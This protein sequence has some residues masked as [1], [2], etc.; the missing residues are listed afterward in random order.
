MG[1]L[2]GFLD[3]A[4]FIRWLLAPCPIRLRLALLARDVGGAP[5]RLAGEILR[6]H[7]PGIRFLPG[8][9]EDSR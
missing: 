6:Y 5:K 1:P 3:Y 7:A 2:A 4:I 9:L 8:H